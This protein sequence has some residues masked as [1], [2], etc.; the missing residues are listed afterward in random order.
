MFRVRIRTDLPVTELYVPDEL[1]PPEQVA[2]RLGKTVSTLK[3]W[4]RLGTGPPY[5]ARL[6]PLR[7]SARGLE[8]WLDS[9]L[10]GSRVLKG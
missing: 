9:Q 6:K 7:Y 4:R 8:R 5:Y 3:T 1:L 2:Q 10:S